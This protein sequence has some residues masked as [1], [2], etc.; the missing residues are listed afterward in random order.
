VRVTGDGAGS[1]AFIVFLGGRGSRDD[2]TAVARPV[3]ATAAE[4]TLPAGARSGPVRLITADRRRSV[5]SRRG[6]A[7][8]APGTLAPRLIDAR[9]VSRRAF[10]DATRR[11]ALDVYAGG[12]TTADVVVDLVRPGD[13]AVLAHW[14]LPSVP[15][16]TVQTVEWDG[17]VA[18]APQPEGRYVF[19]ASVTVTM[20]RAAVGSGGAASARSPAEASSFVLL[21]SR[22]PIAGAHEY[23]MSA[24]RFGAGRGGHSH[25]GQDVFADCGTPMVAARGGRVKFA[26]SQSRAGNYVVI[27]AD[28]GN[29]HVYMHLR[30][31]ALVAKG[32]TVGTGQQ[33]G[34]VGD[35]GDARGC[36]LHFELWAAPGWYTGGSPV[37]PLPSLRG[38]DAGL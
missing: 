15:G 38:W 16:G 23:G 13:N 32:A 24:G 35:T 20:L 27:A 3:N 22:F 12:T 25:Q 9:V 7:V 29:D 33:I 26:G 28:D 1:A 36:H 21:R 30:D 37:D 19:R 11:A 31:K 4:A 10:V 5:R 2:R 34:F 17:T 8:R 6:I 18:G 14:V